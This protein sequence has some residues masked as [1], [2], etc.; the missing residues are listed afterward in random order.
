MSAES[1][2]EEIVQDIIED[3]FIKITDRHFKRKCVELY[4]NVTDA[5][6]AEILNVCLKP[7]PCNDFS[8]TIIAWKLDKPAKPSPRDRL[9]T[10]KFQLC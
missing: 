7:Q 10:P 5:A 3:A 2:V 6:L 4:K 1:K 8:Q 9:S